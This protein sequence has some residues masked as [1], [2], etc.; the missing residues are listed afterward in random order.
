VVRIAVIGHVEWVQHA[1]LDEPLERGA[2][3]QLHDTFEE[4]GG[5]G[6]VAARALPALGAQARFITALGNDAPA[7]ESERVL[8]QDGCDLR[9]ARRASPQNRV[10]TVAEPSGERT[11]LVHG[12]NLHPAID[13]PLDWDE[14]AGF[15][16]VFYTGD[17]SRTVVAARRARVLVATAR[18]LASVV[19][20]RVQ[21]DVLAASARDGGERYDL[22]DLPVRPRLCVWSE[23]ADGGHYLAE[24]GSEGRWEA[25]R[26]PGPIVDTYGAG[27]VFMAALTLEL[28]RGIARDEALALA[29]RASAAQLT[30]RG[31]GSS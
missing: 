27:D 30:R 11:I 17:D 18:R 7:D 3:I 29:A 23:G 22:A 14:L 15:D 31:G 8:R 5:G 9:V 1:R 12:P 16:G 21:V 24:D 28:A 6:G 4:P 13:D 10:T 20:S 19:E 25:A 2:I 26:P